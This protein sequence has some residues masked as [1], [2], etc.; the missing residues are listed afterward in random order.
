MIQRVVL[1]VLMGI[2]FVLSY[3]WFD[4]GQT[5]KA[6]IDVILT[7]VFLALFVAVSLNNRGGKEDDE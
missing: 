6:W 3:H 4:E 2:C 5:L 1:L 7:L